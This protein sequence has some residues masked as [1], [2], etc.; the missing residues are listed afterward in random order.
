[1]SWIDDIGDAAMG[2]LKWL[3][4]SGTAA[5]IA[6]ISA[7]TFLA[8][9]INESIAKDNKTV[10]PNKYKR[11]E[12]A[13][14]NTLNQT[15]Q[16][17][18]AQLS[19]GGTRLQLNPSTTNRIPVLYG[20][21][22]FGGN[23]IDV[24]LEDANTELWLAIVL[25]ETTG[26]KQSDSLPSEYVFNDVFYNGMRIIFQNDGITA[27]Y[28]L[29]TEGKRDD[30]IHDLVEIY[31]FAGGRTLP[32][33]PEYYTNGALDNSESLMP[34]W[35]SGHTMEDLLFAVARIK[36]NQSKNITNIPDLKFA[37]TNSMSLPGDCLYDYMTNTRYGAGLTD[38]E[39]KL[40]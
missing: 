5:A 6:R 14:D 11:L 4:G 29:D 36:Y 16:E 20:A 34:G 23:I 12:G 33:V 15:A 28:L 24:Q 18:V 25:A 8:R 2:A 37:I 9:Q 30:S 31:L 40:T 32:Q 10:D 35:T 7:L 27:D 13:S 21:A 26:E 3:G 38:A 19:S 39:I 1:M 22:T 17:T